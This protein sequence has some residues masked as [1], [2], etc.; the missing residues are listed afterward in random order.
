MNDP[1]DFNP[2]WD[3]RFALLIMFTLTVALLWFEATTDLFFR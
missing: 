3:P 2:F 1:R